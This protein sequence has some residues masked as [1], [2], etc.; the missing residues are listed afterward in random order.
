MRLARRDNILVVRHICHLRISVVVNGL[1]H[2]SPLTIARG[3][4][5]SFSTQS[6]PAYIA[7]AGITAT[8][9]AGTE[10]AFAFAVAV[11]ILVWVVFVTTM[12]WTSVK[13]S[14]LSLSLIHI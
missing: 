3:I 9:A 7:T 6:L 5:A 14:D 4:A 2:L 11:K 10:S 1:H 13:R 12:I 8:Q